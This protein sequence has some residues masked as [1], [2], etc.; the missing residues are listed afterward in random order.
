MPLWHDEI[1]FDTSGNTNTI[2]KCH[3]TLPNHISIDE[4][5]HIHIHIQAKMGDILKRD[6]LEIE[7]YLDKIIEI[8]VEKLFIKKTQTVILKH[9]G[10]PQINTKDLF[11][12]Q[13]IGH[14]LIHIMLIE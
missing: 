9:Y 6:K 11:D 7:L 14:I 2:V 13:K 12:C 4:N 3:P 5:N 8:E 1:S 10:I